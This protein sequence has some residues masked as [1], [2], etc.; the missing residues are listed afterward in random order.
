MIK[1]SACNSDRTG[2][3]WKD[4]QSAKKNKNNLNNNLNK[5]NEIKIIMLCEAKHQVC[6]K[7]YFFTFFHVCLIIMK[8]I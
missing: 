2:A 6:W 4:K 8:K 1:N 5:Y 3:N 7:E